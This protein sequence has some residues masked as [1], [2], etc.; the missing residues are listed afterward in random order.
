MSL[1]TSWIRAFSGLAF[2]VS[3]LLFA[4]GSLKAQLD[5]GLPIVADSQNDFTVAG[6]QGELDWFAGYYNQTID[7]DGVYDEIDD[8]I[9]FTNDGTGDPVSVGGNHWSGTGWDLDPDGAPWT[10]VLADR[11]HPNGDNNAEVHWAIRR[12]FSTFDGEATIVYNVTGN[13]GGESTVILLRN[14]EELS[15]LTLAGT[16][17]VGV[18]TVVTISDL[19]E[20]DLIDLALTPENLNGTQGDGNDTT[21]YRLTIYEGFPDTDGDGVD[22]EADNCPDLSNADQADGDSDD[23]GDACDNCPAAANSD[24]SDVDS[25]GIGD[26]CDD[27]DGDGIADASDNCPAVA[28]ADQANSDGDNV[29]D[30]CDNCPSIDNEGQEDF[31]QDGA[32]DACDDGD[33][34]NSELD[35][36]ADGTQGE[37]N[38]ESGWYNYTTDGDQVYQADDFMPFV[39]DGTGNPPTPDGN[40]WT[41]ANWRLQDNPGATAGPWTTL[42]PRVSHPNGTNSTPNEEHWTVRRWESDRA[43]VIGLRYFLAKQNT[44]GGNGVGGKVFHNDVELDSF[45]VG[46]TD[47][48]GVIRESFIEV[49]V[50]D[51]VDYAA[52]PVGPDGGRGDGADGS[53]SWIVLTTTIPDTD[54]DGVNDFLDNCRDIAN[55]DQSDVDG[56]DLGDVCD[57]CDDSID[58]DGDGLGDAC[59]NCVNVANAD[60]SDRD[61][62]GCGDACDAAVIAHSVDD[63]SVDGD[64][65]E[66]D[67][68][69]GYYNET[70]D[71][72]A[73]GY[74]S[75]DFIEF[76]NDGLGTPVDVVTNNWN[77]TQWDLSVA[78]APWTVVGPEVIHPNGS[79]NG[80]VHW[81]I[82]RYEVQSSGTIEA[83]W[84]LRED[85]P[86]GTGVT[87]ILFHNDDEVDRSTVI[88]GDIQGV[89]RS[90][91]LE[92]S[93]GD[94]IDLALTAEG[95]GGCFD[96]A[97][98]SDGSINWL[99]ISELSPAGC[100]LSTGPG[101]VIADSARGFSLGGTQGENDWF[102]G[103]YDQRDDVEA[104]NGVYESGDFQEFDPN[105]WDGQKWDLLENGGAGAGPWTEITCNGGHP[106]ANGQTD[107][108]VHW[109]I[110]RWAS[111]IDGDVRISG[112]L[113]NNSGAGDGVVGRI[114]VNDDE[115]WSGVSNGTTVRYDFV[116]TI[117]DGDTIDFAIDADAS[118][119]LALGGL[120]TITDGA[121]GTHFSAQIQLVTDGGGGGS[122]FVR[123]DANANGQIDLTD[124]I[125]LLNYLFLGTPAPSCLEAADADNNA[126][127]LI[128]DAILIL[129][130][131]FTGGVAPEEPSPTTSNYPASDCGPDPEGGNLGCAS[132]PAKCS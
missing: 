16:D 36:T 63:W 17:T 112:T 132:P 39:N 117:A 103:Y 31:D 11:G 8:F 14:G 13:G 86:G 123:G 5:L 100:G 92:V 59:D 72:D 121:D 62:D 111:T 44:G 21:L 67:W 26:V 30:A 113:R 24:Q 32:G 81:P 74:Q 116:T 70:L 68:F 73:N 108:Q 122:D 25:D 82:R 127:L 52:T 90:I 75:D 101:E 110:R 49:A 124:A 20:G 130:W 37:N 61:R 78:G 109:A 131:L 115:V 56:D 4:T 28:N 43:G 45:A 27:G 10:L 129:G 85:N 19:A 51:T 29:G 91:I 7:G 48:V 55:A 84:H 35:F 79:N 89:Y 50:G 96:P 98:G 65:G 64:Q 120:D 71:L 46:G 107:T 57:P 9:E 69:Y 18:D 1:R 47:G 12:W 125:N 114:F 33:F 77:G 93:S 118:G 119:N 15:R 40:H 42:Q 66:N 22:N 41:G 38:W 87:G 94:T 6:V 34:A 99:Q 102:Y 3:G 126:Q 95:I 106:A 2:V 58:A 60:Q 97:D 83:T 23:V 76:I 88:G 105:T 104:D 54:G 128:N 53:L 80:D